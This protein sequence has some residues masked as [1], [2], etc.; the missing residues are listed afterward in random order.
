M[1]LDM[2]EIIGDARMGIDRIK[3]MLEKVGF[4]LTDTYD[5]SGA[6]FPFLFVKD[7]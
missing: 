4:K 1:F 6:V 7:L 5:A 3:N 2:W